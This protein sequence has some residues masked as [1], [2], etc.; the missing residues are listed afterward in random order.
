MQPC[1]GSAWPL[2]FRPGG[3]LPDVGLHQPCQ[4]AQLG[5]IKEDTNFLVIYTVYCQFDISTLLFQVH[6]DTQEKAAKA[7]KAISLAF[8]GLCGHLSNLTALGIC[9]F[10]PR[11]SYFVQQ[12]PFQ[13]LIDSLLSRGHATLLYPVTGSYTHMMDG[14]AGRRH[15]RNFD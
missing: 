7:K 6:P 3:D 5:N 12:S 4:L 15:G 9:M 8:R 2:L 13:K 11:K 14:R 1:P 10:A